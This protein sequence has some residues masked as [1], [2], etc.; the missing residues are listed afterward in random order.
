MPKNDVRVVRIWTD[1]VPRKGVMTP[2]DKVEYCA[3]GMAQRSTTVA[4]IN[5]LNRVRPPVDNDD[6]AALMSNDIWNQIKPHYEAFKK[7][8]ETPD[9]GTPLGAWP[10]ISQ[11]Q[12]AVLKLNGFR[13]VEEIAQATDSVMGR[14]QLPGARVLVEQA[15]RFLQASDKAV[16]A[17]DMAAKDALIATMR[18]EQEEMKRILLDMQAQAK[19][20]PRPRRG[21]PPNESL[22]DAA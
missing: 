5:Q 4:A 19:S 15:A 2:I 3:I 21:R 20:E 13:T 8:S 16:I 6:I 17:A 1:Y 14:I 10:G 22:E 18:E 12:A 7:G 9:S 11:E